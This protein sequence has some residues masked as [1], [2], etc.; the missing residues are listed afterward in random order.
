MGIDDTVRT[1]RNQRLTAEA[2]AVPAS[3]QGVTKDKVRQVLRALA[4]ETDDMVDVVFA[5]L[6]DQTPSFYSK[7]SATHKVCD[8]ASTAHIACHVGILQRGGNR[9]DR[10][11]RDYW[12][13]PLREPGAIESA[14]LL[15]KE[16]SFVPGWPVAKSSNNCSR[17][18]A[19]FVDILRADDG[20][21]QELLAVWMSED[22]QRHRLKLQAE[23]AAATRRQVDT[24]H[25]DLIQRCIS[26][27]VPEFL[28][29]YD[30]LY[31]DDS[32]GDRISAEEEARL[33]A[34]GVFLEIGDAMPDVLLVSH[35][36]S[37]LWVIEAVTSDGEV[38]RHK[39]EQLSQLAARS[40]FADIQF[41]TAYWT[42][43]AAATR[44]ARH[45]NLAVGSWL[46]I[47]E[48]PGRHFFVSG[49]SRAV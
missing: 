16:G 3:F 46:W 29:N 27:L 37:S 48:D 23:A 44:Q 30:L 41:T 39:I 4:R 33:A 15:S 20:D 26:V 24:K 25:A 7:V 11:G 17:L 18:S 13:K 12:I 47:A 19:D 14:H 10:E 21:W 40:G 6:D 1:L 38:D 45:K 34:A 43:R 2:E 5:L 31:V 42:W 32:D 9:L 49:P 35:A 28:E 8:G 36:Q 22:A